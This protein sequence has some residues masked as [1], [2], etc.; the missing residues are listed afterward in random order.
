[1]DPL[2]GYRQGQRFHTP[3]QPA[4]HKTVLDLAAMPP[5]SP[6]DAGAIRTGHSL[7][8]PMLRYQRKVTAGMVARLS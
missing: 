5:R 6:C 2:H 4:G 8:R 1:M 7:N 3:R